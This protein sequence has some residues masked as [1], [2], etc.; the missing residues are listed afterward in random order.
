MPQYGWMKTPRFQDTNNP[1]YWEKQTSY[2]EILNVVKE[3]VSSSFRWYQIWIKSEQLKNSGVR[4]LAISEK[5]SIHQ[6]NKGQI[7]NQRPQID[8]LGNVRVGSRTVPGVLISNGKNKNN[9]RTKR[10][11]TKQLARLKRGQPVL[12]ND[13]NFDGKRWN[14]DN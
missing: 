13:I 11:T 10:C 14:L 5:Q 3:R 4:L 1:N 2:R 12:S 8:A 9:K 6:S 7:W